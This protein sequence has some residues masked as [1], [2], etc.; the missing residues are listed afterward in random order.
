M[1]GQLKEYCTRVNELRH[2]GERAMN[3]H[4]NKGVCII[5]K[6]NGRTEV[7]VKPSTS[8]AIKGAATGALIGCRFGPVGL[9]AGTA[10]GGILGYVLGED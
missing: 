2:Y 5:E 10:I 6:E 4:A 7:K 3:H 8:G 1:Q 9:A